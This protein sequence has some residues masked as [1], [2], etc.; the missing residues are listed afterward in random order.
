MSNY[1]TAHR[2][3]KRLYYSPIVTRFDEEH[4]A[5]RV[6]RVCV[7]YSVS[8][9]TVEFFDGAKWVVLPAVGPIVL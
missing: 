4:H 3:G 7:E 8:E 5:R 6:A 2:V 9:A 1:R